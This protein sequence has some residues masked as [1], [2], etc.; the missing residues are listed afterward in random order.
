MTL[1]TL[2]SC[3]LPTV[4]VRF[5]APSLGTKQNNNKDFCPT[6]PSDCLS[7][8]NLNFETKMRG[9]HAHLGAIAP[10]LYPINPYNITMITV[11]IAG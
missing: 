4:D 2:K 9:P 11:T 10:C 7:Y 5:W 3:S 1:L 8:R 6:L